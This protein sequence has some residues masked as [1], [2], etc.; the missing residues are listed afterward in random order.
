VRV[1]PLAV[2]DN[3]FTKTPNIRIQSQ[4]I[5]KT[6]ELTKQPLF[7]IDKPVLTTDKPNTI[8]LNEVLQNKIITKSFTQKINDYLSLN[9]PTN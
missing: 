1:F 3:L 5:T 8:D 4:Q 6:P 2:T 9:K 7:T